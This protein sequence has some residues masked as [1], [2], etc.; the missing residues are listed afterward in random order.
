VRCPRTGEAAAD[1]RV[2]GDP[3]DVL[4]R[5]VPGDL[6]LAA[7]LTVLTVATLEG[8]SDGETPAAAVVLAVLSVAPLAARQRAPVLVT[9]V[10]GAALAAYAVAGYGDFPSGALGLVI[11]VFTVAVLRDRL[12]VAGAFAGGLAVV[13]LAYLMAGSDVVW[14]QVAQAAVIL[15]VAWILGTSVRR[16][17]R[18]AERAAA[19]AARAAAAERLRIA[20]EL[21]DVVSHHMSVVSLQAGLAAYVVDTDVP[22]ARQ[23]IGTA[24]DA[25]REALGEMRRMLGA[26]RMDERTD[27]E[28]AA[29][30]PQ[31]GLAQLDALIDRVRGAG[32][33][34]DVSVSGDVREL[35]PGPDLC[36]YRVIQES[37]TNVLK[38]AGPARAEVALEY[39]PRTVT[40]TVTD[41]GG[42]A[43]GSPSRNG[44]R[45]PSADAHGIRGMRERA[46][47]YGGVLLA[48]PSRD[49]GFTVRLRLPED[50]LR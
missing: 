50:D 24:S 3:V 5:P 28:Q 8:Q 29:Y 41:D 25:G 35:P 12:V 17:A 33:D 10:I 30:R 37:L 44:G 32:L 34:V 40:V 11:A 49:G 47:L 6:L 7:V 19:A 4:L 26:L 23:A 22:T 9:A 39:G 27:D 36:A 1:R 46:E 2:Y 42:G 20:R 31:P 16:W 18:D 13:V 48:G 43:P 15:L 21:H 14:S 38:H 45:A